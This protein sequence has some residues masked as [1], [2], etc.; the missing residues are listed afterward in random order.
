VWLTNAV[1]ANVIAKNWASFKF[2][3]SEPTSRAVALI[4]ICV[5]E[6]YAFSLKTYNAT[7]SHRYHLFP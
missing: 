1:Y 2:V 5:S 7:V 3:R 4:A 6:D